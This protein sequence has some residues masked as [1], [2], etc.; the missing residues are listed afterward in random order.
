LGLGLDRWMEDNGL[1][2]G[3]ERFQRY[4]WMRGFG[5]LRFAQDDSK[6]RQGQRG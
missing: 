3:G 1:G 5:V 2:L 6:N 4:A